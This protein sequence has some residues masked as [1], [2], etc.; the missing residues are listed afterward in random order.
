MAAIKAK[1]RQIGSLAV[2]T[3]IRI[4]QKWISPLLGPHCRFQPTCSHYAIEAFSRFG[5]LKG[6]W[7]T[8]KRVLK[9]HPLHQGGK[10]PIPPKNR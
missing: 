3:V 2:I 5:F 8:I 10:D 6:C 1:Y 7:L 9:C 4:Y